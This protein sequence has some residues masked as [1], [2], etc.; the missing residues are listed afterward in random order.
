MLTKLF[1]FVEPVRDPVE[2]DPRLAALSDPQGGAAVWGRTVVQ[3]VVSDKYHAPRGSRPLHLLQQLLNSPAQASGG[4]CE[5]IVCYYNTPRKGI[6][7]ERS[8]LAGQTGGFVFVY[9]I[10]LLSWRKLLPNK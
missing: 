6:A 1:T 4:D 7:C 5:N 3:V 10:S 9:K 2:D 8:W